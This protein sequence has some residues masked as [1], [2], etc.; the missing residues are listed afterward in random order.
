MTFKNQESEETNAISNP[1]YQQYDPLAKESVF[2]K[3]ISD[4][5]ENN[6]ASLSLN[7]SEVHHV[8]TTMKTASLGGYGSSF[9]TDRKDI[10]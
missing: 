6:G 1:F 9:A 7:E 2:I 5:E 3:R 4:N 10:K 8:N